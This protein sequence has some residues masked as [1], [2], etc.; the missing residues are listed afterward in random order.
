MLVFTLVCL[1]Y[2]DNKV[3]YDPWLILSDSIHYMNM[4]TFKLPI[5]SHVGQLIQ[6]GN[7]AFFID[8]KDTHLYIPFRGYFIFWLI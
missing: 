4:S 2:L 6:L 1:W 3:V 5:N 8:Y 7:F